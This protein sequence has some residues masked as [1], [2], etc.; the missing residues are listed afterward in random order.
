MRDCILSLHEQ[1]HAHTKDSSATVKM[2]IE[3]QLS[4]T[5]VLF[6][7]APRPFGS[8]TLTHTHTLPHPVQCSAG[9]MSAHLY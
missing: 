9:H 1:T 8:P 5:T 6:I 7:C 4:L 2:N 3:F